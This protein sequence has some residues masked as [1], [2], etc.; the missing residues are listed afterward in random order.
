MH[1]IS[2]KNPKTFC[3]IFLESIP[4]E[5][6]IESRLAALK[7]PTQPVPSADEMEDR[8]AA[9]GGL[10]PPSKA[11]PPVNSFLVPSLN[12]HLIWCFKYRMLFKKNE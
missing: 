4:S 11:P 1:F 5:K 12:F 8:L 2:L 6:E 3:M 9:L 10:P 7:A